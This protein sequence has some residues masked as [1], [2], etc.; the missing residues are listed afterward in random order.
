LVYE[1]YSSYQYNVTAHA[2]NSITKTM[3][4]LLIGWAV[5]RGLLDIDADITSAYGVPSPRPYPVTARQLMSQAVA[6]LHGPGESWLYDAGGTFWLNALPEVFWKATGRRP[7]AVWQE[8]FAGPLGLSESFKWQGVD[9][10]WAAGSLGTCRDYSRLGQLMLNRGRW[11]GVAEPIV[12][13]DY[14]RQMHTP[15]T[16][17]GPYANYSNPCYGLLTWLNTNPHS[18]RGSRRYPGQCRFW[19]EE[20]WLPAGSAPNVYVASGIM[21]QTIMVV[22][23]HNLVVVS[24]GSTPDDNPVMRVMYEG[25]CMM[26]PSDCSVPIQTAPYFAV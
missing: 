8:Q 17:Y 1:S 25:V 13:E 2:G 22:P 18:D 11:P 4:A 14:V 6:G 19:P 10:T 21:G 7:S 24:M 5:T 15:Q 20:C 12:S 26:F 3:G 9:W 16:K 23:D